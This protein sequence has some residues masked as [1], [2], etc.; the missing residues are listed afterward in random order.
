MIFYYSGTGNSKHAADFVHERFGGHMMDMAHAMRKSKLEYTLE[1]GERVIFVFPVYFGGLPRTVSEFIA[2]VNIQGED[3]EYCGIAT[4]GKMAMGVDHRFKKALKARGMT[5]RAFYDVKMVENCI[6]ILNIPIKEAALM[7]LKRSD[8]RLKDVADSIEFNHRKPYKSGPLERLASAVMY[9]FYGPT[10]GT[11][12][13]LVEDS[14]IGCGL[15]Q[16]VCPVNAIEMDEGR[17]V[18]TK[19][20]CDHC[21]GCIMK[22]PVQAIQYG[23]GT[24]KRFRYVHPDV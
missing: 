15:C 4:M 21:A 10:S 6:F 24:R 3:L 8:A 20:T 2:A 22:C 19:A 18:W 12:K 5:M 16:T 14:C 9:S 17:P 1:K 13:F 23:K 11:K 7:T